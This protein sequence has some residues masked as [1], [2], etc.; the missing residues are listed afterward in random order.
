MAEPELP[1]SKMSVAAMAL[2]LSSLVLPFIEFAALV[3]GIIALVRRSQPMRGR[4]YAWGGIGLSVAGLASTLMVASVFWMM[5]ATLRD[6]PVMKASVE[7]SVMQSAVATYAE[8]EAQGYPAHVAELLIDGPLE[9]SDVMMSSASG[10]CMIGDYNCI[11]FDRDSPEDVAALRA[12]IDAEDLT[13]PY[14]DFGAVTWVR[15]PRST[16]DEEIIF[17]WTVLDGGQVILINDNGQATG[18]DREVWDVFWEID[19]SGRTRLELPALEAPEWPG[20]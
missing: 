11:K 4:G 9:V 20:F 14:Y 12:A 15:L 18:V 5:F 6:I 10:E 8:T 19:A 16:S 3:V 17:A 13:T 1:M 2:G 7:A